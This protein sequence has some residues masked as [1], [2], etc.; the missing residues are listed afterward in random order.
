MA[1]TK[2]E[3]ENIEVEDYRRAAMSLNSKEG[4]VL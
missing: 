3:Q 4:I 1:N 2:K